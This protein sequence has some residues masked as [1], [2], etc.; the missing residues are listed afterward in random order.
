MNYKIIRFR[1]N[2]F[3]EQA[4]RVAAEQACRR[5]EDQARWLLRAGLGIADDAQPFEN[6]NRAGEVLPDPSAVAA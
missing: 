1:V 3:E 4:L 5:P 6:A 2:E